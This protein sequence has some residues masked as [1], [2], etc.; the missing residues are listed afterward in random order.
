MLIR[1]KHSM[2][3]FGVIPFIKLQND[4]WTTA[5]RWKMRCRT[6]T[7]LCFWLSYVVFVSSASPVEES[8]DSSDVTPCWPQRVVLDQLGRN[9]SHR[10]TRAVLDVTR[11]IT[12]R[13]SLNK[14]IFIHP[15]FTYL[16]LIKNI[17]SL[18]YFLKPYFWNTEEEED[19]TKQNR[20]KGK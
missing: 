19:E 11:P 17:L 9:T 2:R 14:Y 12:N 13:T 3:I 20:R 6:K 1:T 4:T 18:T 10:V 5:K 16:R 8:I 7:L 15:H